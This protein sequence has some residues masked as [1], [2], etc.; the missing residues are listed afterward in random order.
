MNIINDYLNKIKKEYPDTSEINE[1]IEELRDT[2]H[3]KTEEFQAQGLGYE[4]ATNAAIS[5]LGDVTGLFEKIAG[6]VKT[7]YINRL[8]FKGAML[9]A[10]FI[11]AMYIE[12]GLIISALRVTAFEVNGGWILI[13]ISLVMLLLGVG[14]W[15]MAMAVKYRKDPDKTDVISF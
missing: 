11:I 13:F 5:S 6:N 15:I 4:D 12:C 8:N 9:I 2:L 14:I 1:Q 10:A 3:L 7:V